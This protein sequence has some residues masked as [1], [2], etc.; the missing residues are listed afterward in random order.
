M[1]SYSDAP[2][3]FAPGSTVI[4]SVPNG[5]S[6][7]LTVASSRP[8]QGR[9]LLR[10]VG[11][12]DRAEAERF[13]G[14]ELTILRRDVGPLPEGRYYRFELLGL[15]AQTREG[16]HLGEVTD[17]FAT[18]SNDVYV[19]RGPRGEFLLPALADVVVSID[20]ELRTM[21]VAPPP[22]LPGLDED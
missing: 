1:D 5:V 4:A 6:K 13:H 2:G 21:T 11:I 3:R 18:G 20:R 12:D 14:A 16:E 10:F 22:G 8:F 15:R 17:V 7:P 9:L 19:I